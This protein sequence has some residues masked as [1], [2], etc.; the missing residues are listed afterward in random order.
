MNIKINL[1]TLVNICGYELPTNLQNFTQNSLNRSENIPKSFRGGYFFLKHPLDKIKIQKSQQTSLYSCLIM[2]SLSVIWPV[3]AIS[4]LLCRLFLGIFFSVLAGKRQ[5]NTCLSLYMT[6]KNRS[7]SA[8]ATSSAKDGWSGSHRSERM[9]LRM[10]ASSLWRSAAAVKRHRCTWCIGELGDDDRSIDGVNAV[11]FSAVVTREQFVR[12]KQSCYWHADQRTV[13]GSELQKAAADQRRKNDEFMLSGR[14][15]QTKQ[16]TAEAWICRQH[17]VAIT[18]MIYIYIG[19]NNHLL[20][21]EQNGEQNM[22]W[23]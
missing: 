10:T 16:C 7:S 23:V 8:A 12:L 14:W 3:S 4:D 22:Q 13:T 2:K 17:P 15:K 21:S 1:K 6:W 11:N 19:C 20:S 5:F 18:M 9:P